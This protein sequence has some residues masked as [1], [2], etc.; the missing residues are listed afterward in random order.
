MKG[1]SDGNGW[2]SPLPAQEAQGTPGEFAGLLAQ[3]LA[4]G[5]ESDSA[6]PGDIPLP[7]WPVETQSDLEELPEEAPFAPVAPW[8]SEQPVPALESVLA[9][10]QPAGGAPALPESGPQGEAVPQP[11]EAPA[12]Q[13]ELPQPVEGQ[14]LD[15]PGGVVVPA[16][17]E[18]SPAPVDATLQALMARL[19]A[20]GAKPA[21]E[22]RPSTLRTRDAGAAEDSEPLVLEEAGA[23]AE[24][25]SLTELAETLE[26]ALGDAKD[27]EASHKEQGQNDS[28]PEVRLE[29]RPQSNLRVTAVETRPVSAEHIDLGHQEAVLG[30]IQARIQ[31]GMQRATLRLNPEELGRVSIDLQVEKG[32]VR[33]ELRVESKEALSILQRHLPEL[34]EMFAQAELEL[35]ELNLS[36]GSGEQSH[37]WQEQLFEQNTRRS[38]PIGRAAEQPILPA[39]RDSWQTLS[40]GSDSLDLL[41]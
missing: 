10:V 23:T 12:P 35:T 26:A 18:P 33:A 31:P 28:L 27:G 29:T 36:L 9:P 4:A 11:V 22:A 24:T 41:A 6:A 17:G 16:E 8:A 40:L 19:N 21:A 14:A 13:V 37:D 15:A 38:A 30:Q 34:R 39:S 32:E 25:P 2:P 5:K 7:A 20:A 3:Q 1:R